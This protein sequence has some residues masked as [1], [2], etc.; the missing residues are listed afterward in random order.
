MKTKEQLSVLRIISSINFLKFQSLVIHYLLISTLSFSQNTK[1]EVKENR[2]KIVGTQNND[3]RKYT[4][5]RNNTFINKTD[6]EKGIL[7]LNK[8][9]DTTRDIIISSNSVSVSNPARWIKIQPLVPFGLSYGNPIELKADKK[10]HLYLNS[11]IYS[12]DGKVITLLDSNKLNPA[13]SKV[14]K[15]TATDKFL[16]VIDENNITVLRIRIISETNTIEVQFVAF[17]ANGTTCNI[18][19]SHGLE[20]ISLPK[21]YLKMT[22]SERDNFWYVCRKKIRESLEP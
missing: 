11:M 22:Q 21:P 19:S 16:E 7:L 20:I 4:V 1:V 8:Y 17:D 15:Q 12:A 14:L 9:L 6:G 18:F 5:I 2:G 3:N 13:G 10:E